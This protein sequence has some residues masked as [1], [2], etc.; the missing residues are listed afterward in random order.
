MQRL[1]PFSE[2]IIDGLP[3]SKWLWIGGWSLV[4]W[5]NALVNLS[6][7]QESRSAVWDEGAAFV[8]LSYSALSVAVVITLVGASAL[9]NRIAR[10]DEGSPEVLAHQAPFR[11]HYE[12]LGPVIG[13]LVMALAFG[14]TT[15]VADAG[16]WPAAIRA[17]TWFVLGIAIWS[18]LWTY[19]SLQLALDR[20]GRA[21][22]K[23]DAVNV[24]PDL[25]LRPFG[26]AAFLGLWLLLAWLVPV[27]WTGLSDVVGFVIGMLA[28]AVGLA[29]F[30]LS[31][32]RLHR[33]MT[34]V[35]SRE[36]EVARALYAEAYAPV[37]A[38]PTLETLEAQRNLL[39]AADGLEKRAQ[40]IWEWPIGEGT[41]ARVITIATSVVAVTIARLLLDPFGL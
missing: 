30:F 19:G 40:G 17:L 15:L 34:E 38:A 21:H 13:A 5:I 23:A 6:L 3:G 31:L 32:A 11:P 8:V 4:P 25:G 36:L 18:F 41:L 27:V 7:D 22:L 20:L 14:G 26:D 10:I 1:C 9:A 12:T 16:W 39:G 29:I 28:L 37:R 33:R 24:A 35:K 2:R